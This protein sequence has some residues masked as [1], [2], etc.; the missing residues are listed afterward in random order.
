[1]LTIRV[2]SFVLLQ[3]MTNQRTVPNVWV[4]QQFFGGSDKT[5]AAIQSGEFQRLLSAEKAEL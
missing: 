5:V 2:Q 1:L 4:K 3:E